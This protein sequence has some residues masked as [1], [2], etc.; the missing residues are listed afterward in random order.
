M[1]F[2]IAVLSASV[3]TSG[4]FAAKLRDASKELEKALYLNSL[5]YTPFDSLFATS[6]Y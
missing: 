2:R 6:Y 1:K 4:Y 3:G 5:F